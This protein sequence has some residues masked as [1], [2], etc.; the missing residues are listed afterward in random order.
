MFLIIILICSS[1]YSISDDMESDLDHTSQEIDEEDAVIK[2]EVSETLSNQ[3][4]LQRIAM[5]VRHKKN[6]GSKILKSAWMVHFTESD[7]TV[8]II[9]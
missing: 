5:S 1:G 2:Q 7:K 8:N 3:I 4:P 6:R 9:Y